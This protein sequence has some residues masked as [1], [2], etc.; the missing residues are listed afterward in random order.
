MIKAVPGLSFANWTLD[1]WCLMRNAD[2]CRKWAVRPTLL[3]SMKRHSK[4]RGDQLKEGTARNAASRNPAK[5]PS[6]KK[7]LGTASGGSRKLLLT[8]LSAAAAAAIIVILLLSRYFP[9]ATSVRSPLKPLDSPKITNLPQVKCRL[10]STWTFYIMTY[11]LCFYSTL[12]TPSEHWLIR[13]YPSRWFFPCQHN[14]S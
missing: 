4:P 9:R 14:H 2:W 8:A 10:F 7:G 1:A 6:R 5:P 13:R 12:Q 11:I 3:A